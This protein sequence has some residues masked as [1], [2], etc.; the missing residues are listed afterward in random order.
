MSDDAYQDYQDYLDGL[1]EEAAM[2]GVPRPAKRDEDAQRL[3][4]INE[5]YDEQN[6][7]WSR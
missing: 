4:E 7:W 2:D 3:Q 1:E 6:P 5:K